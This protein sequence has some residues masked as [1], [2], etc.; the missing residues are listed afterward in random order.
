M[1][2]P[3]VSLAGHDNSS[4]SSIKQSEEPLNTNEKPGRRTRRFKRYGSKDWKDSDIAEQTEKL[5]H[6]QVNENFVVLKR[7]ADPYQDFKRSM[8]EMIVERRIFEPTDLEQLLMSFLSLNS[9]MHHKAILKAFSDI[10]KEVFTG[11]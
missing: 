6:M 7:S 9:R 5:E 1:K 10:W 4:S 11:P 2:K 3:K 8:L